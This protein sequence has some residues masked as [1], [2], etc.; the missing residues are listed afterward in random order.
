M[1]YL[2]DLGIVC[3]LGLTR[4]EVL[5]NVFNAPHTGIRS[6]TDFCD[7]IALSVGQITADI[8]KDETLSLLERSRTNYLLLAALG[9]IRPAVDEAIEKYGHERIGVLVGT[10]TSGILESE[11]AFRYHAEHGVFPENFH[12]AQQ[13]LGSSASMLASLLGLRGPA[14][15]HSNACASSAKALISAARLIRMGVCDAVLAGGVDSLSTFVLSGFMSLEAVS[16]ERSSPMSVNRRGINIGEGAALFLMSRKSSSVALCGWGETTDGYHI[17]APEPSGKSA[18]EAMLMAIARAGIKSHDIDYVNMHGTA[19]LQ[20]DA[21]E[22]KIIHEVFGSRVA[23]SST[24]PMTGHTLGA[25]G[26]IEAALCWLIMQDDNPQG[27]LPAHL[28]DSQADPL[29][30]QLNLTMEGSSIGRP[31]KWCL[32]NSFAFGGS[33][34]TLVL[35]RVKDA[36]S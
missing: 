22:A 19:T 8:V 26:A 4:E 34:A 16:F 30:P 27:M 9:Q 13:E 2:N 33:N 25:A 6:S 14:Y 10:C 35:G 24:K 17:S 18:K 3:S 28:W 1:F 5:Y 31:L 7:G 11:I 23:V 32:S 12:Y 36:V 29:L 21:M 15:A 20:N